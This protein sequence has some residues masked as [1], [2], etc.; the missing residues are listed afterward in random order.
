MKFNSGTNNHNWKLR[1]GKFQKMPTMTYKQGV[2]GSNPV[3]PTV[4]KNKI[5]RSYDNQRGNSFFCPLVSSNVLVRMGVF[6]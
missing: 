6:V 5:S 4:L 2:T 1:S 3:V